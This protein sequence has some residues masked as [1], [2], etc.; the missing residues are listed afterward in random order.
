MLASWILETIVT[1]RND[2]SALIRAGELPGRDGQT[3]YISAR[4]LARA[5]SEHL[6]LKD[7]PLGPSA[8]SKI[9]RAELHLPTVRLGEGYVVVLEE[10]QIE[11]LAAESEGGETPEKREICLF[12]GE[13][14]SISCVKDP[15]SGKCSL[16]VSDPGRHTLMHVDAI[17]LGSI[18]YT[19]YLEE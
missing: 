10:E 8:T 19:T 13:G 18:R 4:D 2:N 16:V 6:G 5:V 9:C 3:K 1:L 14:L 15:V 11:R 17:N 7:E 12:P